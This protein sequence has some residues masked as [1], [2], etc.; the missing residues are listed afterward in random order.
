[1]TPAQRAGILTND[2]II[3]IDGKQVYGMTLDA[4]VGM[5]RGPVGSSVKL[6]VYRQGEAEPMDFDLSRAI[7]ARR[8][9]RWSLEGDIGVLR[10]NRF[11]EQAFVGIKSAIEEIYKERDGVAPKGLVLDL[12]NNPGGLVDQAVFVTDA[13]L[14]QGSVV[15]T[16]G[17]RDRESARYDAKPDPLD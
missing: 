4:A 8:A 16:R 9:V 7:V 1:D 12:R 17:R 14:K 2:Y 15:L 5:M 6:T 10:L 3:E 13:F 11:T